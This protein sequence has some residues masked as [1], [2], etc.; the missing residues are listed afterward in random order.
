VIAVWTSGDSTDHDF[1]EYW[2][3]RGGGEWGNFSIF[4]FLLWHETVFSSSS[5]RPGSKAFT[6]GNN[7]LV[8]FV[9]A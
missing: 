4:F 7:L 6:G 8:I 3:G 1:V 9:K 5:L 2:R